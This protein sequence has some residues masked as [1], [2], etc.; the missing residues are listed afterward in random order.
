MGLI[1]Y[2]GVEAMLTGLVDYIEADFARSHFFDKRLDIIVDPDVPHDLF[3][4]LE[5]AAR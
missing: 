1:P 5:R 4:M 3:G 2:V